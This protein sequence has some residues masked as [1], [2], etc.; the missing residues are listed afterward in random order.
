MGSLG[1]M[2]LKIAQ[3]GDAMNRST[4]TA[5]W[6]CLVLAAL[7]F[8]CGSPEAIAT[9]RRAC[10]F[11]AS[12]PA[13]T[14]GPDINGG[15]CFSTRTA[16][17]IG[18]PDP[19]RAFTA[20]CAKTSN[21]CSAFRDCV[22]RNHGAAYCLLNPGRT[23]DQNILVAC[24]S[25][26]TGGAPPIVD[27]N[28]VV[29]TIDCAAATASGECHRVMGSAYCTTGVPCDG[30]SVTMAVPHCDGN[31]IVS[32]VPGVN[33]LAVQSDCAATN[34]TC[35]PGTGTFATPQCV[36]TGTVCVIPPGQQNEDT[37]RCVGTDRTS[38]CV[39]DSTVPRNPDGS[40][41]GHLATYSCVSDGFP[42]HCATVNGLGRCVPP[43][44]QCAPDSPDRCDGDTLTICVNGH[45]EGTPCGSIGFSRCTQLTYRL[46]ACSNNGT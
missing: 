12:C 15:T 23:C 19:E 5:M 10:A 43:D 42:G 24:P 11:E 25:A 21:T 32:C 8:G 6:S 34:A 16:P 13:M 44:N 14:L 1:Q 38:E 35:V 27:P 33:R 22:S 40:Q 9:A 39:A 18:A 29:L 28:A 26:G 45:W 7:A 46:A 36:P 17:A 41:V 31:R 30:T 37:Y 3:T 2:D 4:M 20:N